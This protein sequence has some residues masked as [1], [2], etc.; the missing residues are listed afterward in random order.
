MRIMARDMDVSERTIRRIVKTD[1]KLSP[2]KM[3]TRQQLTDLQKEKRL[4]RA[5]V[6]LNKMKACT[7]ASEVIFSDEKLFTV[8]VTF[9]SQND[10]VLTKSSKDI[11]NSMRTAY[12]RQKPSS[13]MVW[14]AISKTWNPP[15]FLCQKG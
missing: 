2:L 7:D 11:P 14:A 6:L 10:R 9:N 1:L 3:R 13:V 5:K 4:A 15:W 8:E 12:R